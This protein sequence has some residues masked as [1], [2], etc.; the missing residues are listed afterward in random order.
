[1]PPTKD[2]FT[3]AMLDI[4]RRA[5][6]EAK[7]EARI[8]LGMV[9]ESGGLETA[10]YLLH[11]PKVSDGYTALWQRGRLDLTVEAMILDPRWHGLF[12]DDERKIA[13][14]RLRTYGYTG[15]LPKG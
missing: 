7:Y 5:K 11:A 13:V 3:E 8:F 1:M 6:A 10:Q 2:D 4:Y 12:S 15:Q 9:V 14:D